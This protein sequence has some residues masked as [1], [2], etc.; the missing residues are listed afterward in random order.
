[1]VL[2]NHPQLQA[3]ECVINPLN[4]KSMLQVIRYL[5]LKII[6]FNVSLQL[7]PTKG[8]VKISKYSFDRSTKA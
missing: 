5:E 8:A 4:L 2:G 7:Q 1:M 6:T 3:S